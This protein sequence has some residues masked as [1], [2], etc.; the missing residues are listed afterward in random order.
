MK[1]SL[2]LLPPQKKADLRS[3]GILSHAQSMVLLVLIAAAFAAVVLLAVRVVLTTNL[4][5]LSNNT[6]A[7][8]TAEFQ[9]YTEEIKAM[10]SHAARLAAV[11][12]GRNEW[13]KA[14]D[15]IAAALPDGVTIYRIGLRATGRVNISGL[16]RTRDDVLT[17]QRNL[18]DSPIF[19]DLQSP[20][21]N[22]LQRAEVKFDLDMAYD[23][24]RQPPVLNPPPPEK[25]KGAAAKE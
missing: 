12:S 14:L 16:G 3:A 17:F 10:N 8:D 23:E 1:L 6:A 5:N 2:N 15:G 9:T 11:T 22:I 19:S 20:L 25:R 24:F 4:N 13:S 7:P 18:K 21:T